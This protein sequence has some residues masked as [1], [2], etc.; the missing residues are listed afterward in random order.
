MKTI[1]AFFAVLCLLTSAAYAHEHEHEHEHEHAHEH[2]HEHAHAATVHVSESAQQTIGLKTVTLAKRRVS[3]L[4][5]LPGRFELAPDARSAAVAPT[6]GRL[7]LKAAALATIKAG[8]PLFE[9]DSAELAAKDRELAVIEQRLAAYAEVGLTNAELRAQ[10]EVKRSERAAFANGA[11]TD[12]HKLLVKAATN[13]RIE[14]IERKAGEQV[15]SGATILTL[16]RPD[17]L[18]LKLFVAPSELAQLTPGQTATCRGATGKLAFGYEGTT[19]SA[20]YLEFP[21]NAPKARPGERGTAECVTDETSAEA[22]AVPTAAIVKNGL[23]PIVFVRDE[24]EAD[25]F[26]AVPVKPLV[27]GGGWTA[28]EGLDDP[29]AEVVTDGVYELKLA[30]SAQ[31]G[32]KK[33]AGHFHA[34]G[35]FHEGEDE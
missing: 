30:L 25:V 13:G 2:E 26:L 4:L 27:T 19:E 14:R 15:E 35:T 5:S 24:D 7:H 31:S 3:A 20:V 9:I 22:W 6:P 28:I 23:E 29:D 8:D 16:V 1:P 32:Q 11:E 21:E 17:R 18:R 33:A 10:L 12:G 34:D